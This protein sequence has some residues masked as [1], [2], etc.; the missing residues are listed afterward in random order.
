MPW[1]GG[2]SH[3]APLSLA[4]RMEFVKNRMTTCS[5]KGDETKVGRQGK[6]LF[7]VS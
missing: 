5:D 3:Q 7:V 2:G 6:E 1:W 4:F